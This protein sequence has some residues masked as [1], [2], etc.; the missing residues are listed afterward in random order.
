M[1]RAVQGEPHFGVREAMLPHGV[2]QFGK[3]GTGALAG[4]R[5][6]SATVISFIQAP[7]PLHENRRD[8]CDTITRMHVF[9]TA[10]FFFL[11]FGNLPILISCWRF[12]PRPEDNCV[13]RRA[14]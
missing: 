7:R 8:A 6:T 11:R 10:R 3:C 5:Q 1:T 13:L 14:L 4:R 12:F 9:S 2:L